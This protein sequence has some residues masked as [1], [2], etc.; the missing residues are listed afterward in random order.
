ML[1]ALTCCLHI[2]GEIFASP[3]YHVK[4]FMMQIEC[5]SVWVGPNTESEVNC[6][7]RW[8][9]CTKHI[10]GICIFIVVKEQVCSVHSHTIKGH[11]WKILTCI[12]LKLWST[13]G[14]FLCIFSSLT[15]VKKL[16]FSKLDLLR[17]KVPARLY[18]DLPA[19]HYFKK[20]KKSQLCFREEKDLSRGPSVIFNLFPR[21]VVWSNEIVCQGQTRLIIR[22]RSKACFSIQNV[23]RHLNQCGVV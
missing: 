13:P 7:L 12:V 10:W 6:N 3:L 14:F 4:N 19:C 18:W 17:W 22:V 9:S 2:W 11:L 21:I 8:F 5:C 23:S 1:L 16:V 15:C 20:V